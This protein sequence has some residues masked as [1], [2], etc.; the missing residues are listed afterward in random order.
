MKALVIGGT[1]P[2]GH[3]IV[4]GL[5]RRS[6]EV[7]IL[8]RGHHEV[9]E[10]PPQVEHHHLD[11]YDPDAIEAF[12]ADRRFDLCIATYGRLRA[13]AAVTAGR[14]GRFISAGGVP[15]YR[16]YMNPGL[17][18]PPGLA[19]PTAEE[20]ELVRTADEDA[21]GW[22]IVRTEE[23][24]F[25]DHP[26]ATHI[27]YPYVYGQY[28]PMPREWPIVRRVLERRPFIIL[29]DGGLT[30]HHMGYAENVARGILLAVDHPERSRGR[31]YNCAD[32]EVLSLRQLTEIIADTL[33]HPIEIVSMPWEIALPARPLVMQPMTTHRVLD[34]ARI[35]SELGYRDAVPAREAV[36]RTALWLAANPPAP[37]GVEEMVLQDP[38]DYAAED[39]LLRAWRSA[40]AGIPSLRFSSEPGYT[41]SYSGPGGRAPS[42][43]DFQA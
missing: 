2:T 32:D 13:I 33:D 36:A 11:P 25:S 29:P 26:D 5:L 23:A 40:M 3:H 30:L 27:R 41:L 20:A 21:K 4:N 12:F 38:F 37:G 28:Q 17:N 35:R 31:I 22:R 42:K 10:I 1:G 14:V 15:A 39:E 18:V 8:H 16:G 43:A 34:T 24:V 19:V 7:A 6:F 9:P